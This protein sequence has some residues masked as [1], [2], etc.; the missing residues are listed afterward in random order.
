MGKNKLKKFAQN[1]TFANLVQPT[2]DELLE[3]FA[4]KGNW[5]KDF[6]ENDQPIV[7]ELG[8]GKGEYSVGLAERFPNKN[9]VG[10][11]IKGAR[12][13]AGASTALVNNLTNVGFLRTQIEL[14]EHCFAPGEISEIWVTFPDPQ[15]KFRRAKH[16]LTAPLFLNRYQR[17]LQPDGVVHLKT[18]SEFLHGYTHGVLEILGY[19][20]EEAYHDID[21][22]LPDEPDHVLHAITTHYEKLFRKKGKTI[23]YIRWRF[24]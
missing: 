5:N 18:D 16:R 15:I 8:C 10:V 7:L 19:P 17:L 14:L 23:T 2:R 12:L 24:S 3:G 6:F 4:L 11:D 21:F 9:F 22:Q 20:I 13:W 1:D